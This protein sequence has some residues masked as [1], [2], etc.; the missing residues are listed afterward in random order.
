MTNDVLVEH[1]RSALKDGL[2]FDLSNPN[3]IKTPERIAKM[4]REWFSNECVDMDCNEMSLFPNEGYDQIILMKNI[5]FTSVCSHHFLPFYGVAHFAYL[6]NEW[7]VG[8]SKLIRVIE[9]FSKRPQLQESLGQQVID[10]FVKSVKPDGAMLILEAK[11][12]C[13]KCRGVC[14]DGAT[15]VTSNIHG[16]FEMAE[17]KNEVLEMI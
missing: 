1:I 10:F 6:P 9:H 3:L 4:W 17:V 13:I 2:G 11:H 16:V 5:K 8:A 15:M 12:M 14:N 7:L